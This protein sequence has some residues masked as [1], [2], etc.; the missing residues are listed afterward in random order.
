[1]TMCFL[2]NVT[3]PLLSRLA[4]IQLGIVAKLDTVSDAKQT[5]I[6][7]YPKQFRCLGCMS[8]DYHI[9]MKPGAQSYAVYTLRRIPLPHM[10]KVKDEI[11]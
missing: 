11:D 2:A 3:T 6:D 10:S 8:G 4:G 7:K 5:I 1:M 9:Q